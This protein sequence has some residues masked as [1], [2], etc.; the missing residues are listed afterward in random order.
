MEEHAAMPTGATRLRLWAAREMRQAGLDAVATDALLKHADLGRRGAGAA[1]VRGAAAAAVTDCCSVSSVAS[2]GSAPPRRRLARTFFSPACRLPDSPDKT[3]S[4][5]DTS[6]AAWGLGA[7]VGGQHASVSNA[8]EAEVLGELRG[9]AERFERRCEE[10]LQA[11]LDGTGRRLQSQQ[12]QELQ[13]VSEAL[14]VAAERAVATLSW[15]VDDRL[16][17]LEEARKSAGDIAE[18][19]CRR[20]N[21]R[22]QELELSVAAY[23]ASGGACGRDV[24]AAV[25]SALL[26]RRSVFQQ[27]LEAHFQLQDQRAMDRFLHLD[28]E[29]K[30]WQASFM[31]R[32]TALER[33][34]DELAEA[35][36]WAASVPGTFEHNLRSLEAKVMRQAQEQ[37]Q[38]TLCLREM[39]QLV[40]ARIAAADTK[41]ERIEAHCSVSEGRL[42]AQL[43]EDIQA[44]Q[45]LQVG[46]SR[47][48]DDAESLLRQEPSGAP[49]PGP[50]AT[51]T[52]STAMAPTAATAP[53]P[54]AATQ[55]AS[56]PAAASAAP[57]EPSHSGSSSKSSGRPPSPPR[58]SLQSPAPRP[59][60]A[61][62][63]TPGC[64]H[65]AAAASDHR[66]PVAT[67]REIVTQE[68]MSRMRHDLR[69]VPMEGLMSETPSLSRCSSSAS[70]LGRGS[71]LSEGV[72]ADGGC[73]P[74]LGLPKRLAA[75]FS[76]LAVPPLGTSAS[77]KESFV[78][79]GGCADIERWNFSTV[80][81]R[82]RMMPDAARLR[83][84]GA[85]GVTPQ[86]S[87]EAPSEV[88]RR[89]C[90][91]QDA[92][93]RAGVNY[94]TSAR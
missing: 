78:V 60:D 93:V 85:D 63:L 3:T 46:V 12:E 83:T 58:L 8:Q 42:R 29:A 53:T 52:P 55:A 38:I 54:A 45:A 59:A 87:C 88:A 15:A 67:R 28:G 44:M 92:A 82:S 22:M 19:H 40:A 17:Q 62:M 18:E 34:A 79:S 80:D 50:P 94:R 68:G 16:R 81:R 72:C 61:D 57:R 49:R 89:L 66:T 27:Q 7:E 31:Q 30:A 69:Y 90:V 4:T 86:T 23:E 10:E 84:R 14:H 74:L 47:L 20:V 51:S 64:C 37:V 11:F 71:G 75:G 26:E 5:V 48:V 73:A 91:I 39:A 35:A 9:V 25:D 36:E 1:A 70:Q 2:S 77:A 65:A 43:Y 33:R 76:E 24:A 56:P 32:C 6:G 41:C 21:A 13:H